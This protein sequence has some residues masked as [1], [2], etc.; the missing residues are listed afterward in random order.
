[1]CNINKDDRVTCVNATQTRA[2]QIANP[3]GHVS[4]VEGRDYIVYNKAINPCCGNVT[5]DVGIPSTSRT[6]ICICGQSYKSNGT[7]WKSASRFVKKQ[8]QIVEK[9]EEVSAIKLTRELSLS[10]N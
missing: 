2:Q 6:Q 3:S 8:E 4:L 7:S 5:L 10:E 1:M 9:T